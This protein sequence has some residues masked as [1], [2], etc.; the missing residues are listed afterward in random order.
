MS[1]R[2]RLY[3][4][5]KE[6]FPIHLVDVVELFFRE[7][8]ARGVEQAW[9]CAG[10]EPGPCE[11]REIAGVPVSVPRVFGPRVPLAKGLNKLSYWVCDALGL[12]RQLWAPADVIQVRDKYVGAVIGLVVAR[13]RGRLF[14]VWLSYPFPESSLARADEASGLRALYERLSG[15]LGML[16]LYRI[17]MP[18]ADHCFVQSE[19]MRLDLQEFHGLE[20]E[21]MTP[22]PMGVTPRVLERRID[23]EP[24]R[25]RMQDPEGV[26]TV[27]YLGTLDRLRR[28]DVM[29]EAFVRVARSRDRV[30]FLIV[31]EG[32]EPLDRRL[33]EDIVRK[34]GVAD[35]F[36]FTG[37]VPIETAWQYLESADI[38]VSPFLTNRVLRVASPTKLVEYLAF[39]K[40]TVANDHPEHSRVLEASGGGVCVPWSVD[41]FADGV[42]RLLD[43]PDTAIEMGR[44]GREWVLANRT[45]DRIAN[46]VYETYL[47]LLERAR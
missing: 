36:E 15:R 38:C 46:D 8:R 32:L 16:L 22:V 9:Y 7:L 31:G 43:D 18:R 17:A 5:T 24:M 14:T 4:S 12:L 33:L 23:P 29:V 10:G 2:F 34:A 3:A 45:Y 47:T 41:G 39:G 30:R 42:L 11:R 1:R 20:A 25:R 13:L 37:Q 26:R 6:P 40:P 44:R 35:R 27:M 21:H 28:L 19:Q